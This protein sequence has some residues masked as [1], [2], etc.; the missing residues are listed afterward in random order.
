MQI[1]ST[2]KKLTITLPWSEAVILRAAL[3]RYADISMDT[4]TYVSV[5]A[6]RMGYGIPENASS[7]KEAKELA[8]IFG[9]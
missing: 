3:L 5:L 7:T 1:K 9:K 2:K 6:A 8:A 4:S